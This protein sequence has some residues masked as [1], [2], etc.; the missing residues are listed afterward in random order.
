M[1]KVF[2]F[3]MLCSVISCSSTNLSKSIGYSAAIGC[4][5][6]GAGGYALSPSGNYNK[7]ANAAAFCAVGAIVSGAVGYLLYSDNPLN[8]TQKK[9]ID[10]SLNVK[11]EVELGNAPV[12]IY[13]NFK[14]LGTSS[15]PQIDLPPSVKDKMPY[16][17]IYTQEVQEQRINQNGNYIYIEPHKAYIY[18][19]EEHKE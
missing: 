11:N 3:V 17:K 19:N 4:A 5:A 8:E 2:G 13:Q 14:P 16:P 6:G 9:S 12:N 1:N 15:L 7:K 10:G 18:T